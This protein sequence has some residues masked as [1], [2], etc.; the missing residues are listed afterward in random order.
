MASYQDIQTRIE[1]IE[2]KLD[3]IM[4][5]F[6]FGTVEGLVDKKIVVKSLKDLYLESQ[7]APQEGQVFP[8]PP[9][10]DLP[11]GSGAGALEQVK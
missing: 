7:G 1:V 2:R 5:H 3:F 10:F 11:V 4:S 8:A 9:D 6:K